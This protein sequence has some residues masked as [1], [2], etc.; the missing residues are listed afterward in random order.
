M[1][2]TAEPM[3][4]PDGPLTVAVSGATGYAGGEVLRLLASHPGFDVRAVAAH[5]SAGSLLGEHQPHLARYADMRVSDSSAE[6]LAGHDVVVL[7]L[8]HGASGAVAAELEKTDP[9][10]LIID[11]AAD[12]RLI[13]AAA[14][15]TYYRSEHQGTW[16]YGLPELLRADGT[17][18]RETLRTST[19][20]AVP[21][22]NVT[23]VTLGVQPLVA[24]GLID[25]TA[26]TAVLANGVSGAGRALKP[27]M[28]ASEILGDVSSYAQGGTHR[29]IP[30]IEQNLAGVLGEDPESTSVRI[31]FLPTLVPV[32]RGIHAT[33]TAPLAGSAAEDAAAAEETLRAALDSAYDDEP[34]VSLLPAGRW[35]RTSSVTGSNTAQIQCAVDARAG[36]A[37]ITVAIDN[38]VRGTAGQALQSAHLALGLDE[39]ASL[40]LEGVAP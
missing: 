8:P 7:A 31:S 39:T 35:P 30:E 6:S 27:H 28:L 38:L 22:C 20:I 4:R 16:D 19:R 1:H 37:L 40:P 26:L 18:Q 17:K 10:A 32:A 34:F 5:S 36:T 33:I 2:M 14:W 9:G 3:T 24:A 13:S 11:L 21:G 15:E 12:H 23:A 25:H 29:H